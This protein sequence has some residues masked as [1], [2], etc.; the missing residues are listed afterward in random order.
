MC[1][2][3]EDINCRLKNILSPDITSVL[4]LNFPGSTTV[5]NKPYHLWNCI[6][7]TVIEFKQY[8]MITVK[9]KVGTRERGYLSQVLTRVK[10][11]SLVLAQGPEFLQETTSSK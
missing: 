7:T 5:K 3:G 6:V 9:K 2:Q 10:D 1:L 11:G 8:G 4:T